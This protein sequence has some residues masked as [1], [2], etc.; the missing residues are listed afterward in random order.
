MENHTP[1]MKQYMLIKNKYKDCVVFFRMGDFYETFYEDAKTTSR[2][3]DIALTKRGIRNSESSIPLAGI[4]YHAL[5]SYLSKMIKS[6]QKVAIVEQLE[7]PKLAK[8]VVRRDVVRIVTPGTVTE[9][10]ILGSNNN[11]V[12]GL[13]PGKTT[14]LCFV[15]LSTG[16]FFTGELDFSDALSELRKFSPSEVI[17]P[18]SVEN[19]EKARLL[20]ESHYVTFASDVDFHLDNAQNLLMKHFKVLSLDGF[21][22][23]DKGAA[24]SCAG[25]LLCYLYETQKNSLAHINT[26]RLSLA[27]DT[28]IMDATTI[29]NLELV[30]NMRDGSEKG[31]LLEVL[32][33]TLT[34]MGKRLLKR[35]MIKPLVD[36]NRINERLLS[37]EEMLHKPFISEEIR[38]LLKNISDLERLVSRVSLGSANPRDLVSLHGSLDLVPEIKKLLWETDSVLLSRLG[39]MDNM[40]ELSR[41]I[42]NSIKDDPPVS[43][44]EGGFV[45]SG[46]SSELDKIREIS[47][48][49]KNIIRDIEEKEKQ[50]TGIKSLKIRYN[51]VFGYYIDVTTPNLSLVPGHYIKKQTLVNSERFITEEL[52]KLE[53][54]ILTAEEKIIVIEQKIFEEV[55]EAVKADT[56]KIQ[57]AAENIAYL[58]VLLSFAYVSQKNQ[59]NR[60]EINTNYRLR[61]KK[62]RHPIVEKITDFVSNDANL[63]EENRV[64]IITGPNMAGKSV[65]MR[66]VALNVL[67][68]Q[69]GCFVPAEEPLIG[70]IDKIF[71]RTGAI[72][73]ISQGQSTFMVEMSETAQILNS[74]T[75]KSLVVLDEIGRG[76][77]T[78]D[79]VA[80][81]WAVAEYLASKVKAKTLF[82]TH[83]HVLNNLEK[84][85]KG[86]RNFNIAVQETDEK[87]IFLRKIL[88]GGTDK[89]YGVHV[90]KLAGM[91]KQV[92]DRSK[93]IQFKLEGEDEISEKIIIETRK[94]K[95]KD[96]LRRDVE[97]VDR[98][99]KSKQLRL[100]EV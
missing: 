2:I 43:T 79:G 30:K 80:I 39:E 8:G 34:P 100:D 42:N 46:Y 24:V 89:S 55:C 12:A 91:P 29:K 20:K 87:I 38:D 76:T 21:G 86:V 53:E 17:L 19:S 9:Q 84:E 98:L 45:K 50:A 26:I 93:E 52:K 7:D 49:A 48:N 66:Q 56:V 51:R 41:L 60:P 68:A 73:D 99:I 14:G 81:A 70:V 40:E 72:D 11:Y 10:N 25:A 23:R 59:Y 77:S 31:T 71:C 88:E 33:K 75:E 44:A 36:I 95:E 1:A 97:E 4:P 78:F 3:L 63:S 92:I 35:F 57:K 61:L 22:L 67:M 96:R 18:M 62:C 54:E 32:D 69:M 94:K 13:L 58:D 74:A 15:D 16:E 82:A 27:K 90:A 47:T 65:Y 28:L 85:V 64:M 37:V 6:G 83:Y 5:D